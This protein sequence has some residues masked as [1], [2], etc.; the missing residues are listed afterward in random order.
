[1]SPATAVRERPIIMSGPMVRAVLDGTKT[2]TRR[3]VTDR[4]SRGNW[5]PSQC[6][7][8]SAWV[9]PGPSPAGNPGP[10]LKASP[11]VA[12]YASRDWPADDG[13]VDRIYPT[14]TRGERLWVKETWQY[15]DWTEDGHPF[16][17]YKADDARRLCD[18]YPEL[19]G[20]R[21]A[22]DMDGRA[23]DQ[24][25]RSP[26]FMPRWASRLTVEIVE[27]RVERLQDIS[28]AD[29]LAEGADATESS[30]TNPMS[31]TAR[32]DYAR[33]WDEI[34]A[35]RGHPYSSNPLC[36]VLGFRRVNAR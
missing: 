13:I 36:W 18:F 35:K 12:G 28:E 32:G 34:N 17:G 6:E 4:N 26:R 30:L 31:G 22:F 25:W 10:Y 14:W 8:E 19:W 33:I 7:M 27:V 21:I 2:Q 29:A 20:E 11:S 9:D 5:R 23:A 1:M 24:R 16:V 15:A 3:V